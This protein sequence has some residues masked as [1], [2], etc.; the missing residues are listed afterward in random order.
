MRGMWIATVAVAMAL[1]GCG[2]G[3]G[4]TKGAPGVPQAQVVDGHTLVTFGVGAEGGEEPALAHTADGWVAAYAGT[5]SGD[6]HLYTTTSTDGQHWNAAKPLG[7]SDFSDQWPCFV[8]DGAGNLHLYFASNRTGDAFSVYH[9]RYTGGSWS[10]PEIVANTTGASDLAVAYANGKF[11]LAEETM[12]TGLV[13]STSNDGS[14]FTGAATVVEQ[15][16]EPSLA[17]L[18]SGKLLLAYMHDGGL[19]AKS[20]KPGSWSSEVT[21]ATGADKLHEPSLVWAG[22]HGVLAYCERTEDGYKLRAR[23]FD[24][25]AKFG[26]PLAGLPTSDGDQ[27]APAVA[28]D[29]QGL[30]GLIWGMKD[31]NGQQGVIFSP[32]A[33]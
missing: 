21:A 9:S 28:A 10:A 27:R 7:S 22:D 6:R 24:A 20:G 31:S 11:V 32:A 19:Y 26:D 5:N 25:Q 14:Q 12:G 18:P 3:L 33:F 16:F 15:G 30:T 4:L 2:K 8:N 13:V 17:V 1:S 23:Q 29:N